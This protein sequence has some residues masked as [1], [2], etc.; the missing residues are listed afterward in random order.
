[1]AIE[2]VLYSETLPSNNEKELVLEKKIKIYESALNKIEQE[3][4]KKDNEIIR[5]KKL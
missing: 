4:F 5:L 1:M 3:N 2:E